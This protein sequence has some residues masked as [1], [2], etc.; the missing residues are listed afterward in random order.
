M[1]DDD[2]FEPRLGKMRAGGSKRGRKYLHQVLQAAGL[3]ASGRATGSRFH[4]SRIGRGAGVGR[5]LAAGDALGRF[6]H[7]RVIVKSRTVRLAGRGM[8]GAR[9][10]LRYLQRDGVTR[11]GEPGSLYGADRDVEDGK[12]FLERCAGDRHQFRFIVSAE[13]GA[14]YADLKPLT[15]RLMAQMEEDLGTRLDWVAVDHFNTGHPHTHILM[16]GRDDKGKDLILARAYLSTGMRERAAEIVSLD[17]GPRS[18]LEVQRRLAREIEQE[19]WTSLDRRLEAA[20]DAQGF[21]RLEGSTVLRAALTGRLAKLERMGLAEPDPEGRWHLAEDI[22][23]T[24][25]RMGERGDI[26]KTMHREMGRGGG[27]IGARDY[28]IFAPGDGEAKPLVGRV[29][30]RGLS[31]ELRDRHYLIVEATDGRTY[32][33]DIGS[34]DALESL[35]GGAV[36]RVEARPA[37]VRVIDRNVAEI[38]AA[39]HGRYSVDLHLRHD[40]SASQAFAETHVRRLEAM[41]RVTGAADREPDGSWRIAPDHLE[42]AAAFEQRQLRDRPVGIE[43]LSRL[44]LEQQLAYDGATWLDQQL[45]AAEPVPLRDAGFGAA[46]RDAQRLRQRWLIDE[47]L[48][49]EGSG[50]PVFRPDLVAVL[51]RRELRRVARQLSDE[52]GLRFAETQ[53]G[54]AVD[55]ILRRHVDLASGRFAVVEKSREFTLVPWRPVL[56]RQIG[57]RVGGIVRENGVSWS[58]GR[59]RGGPAIS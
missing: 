16:R 28:A 13:D 54:D 50:E 36:V 12:V 58:F 18:D 33:V 35:P 48:A 26:I 55:G 9:A 23:A 15:R 52:L 31:D 39:N 4:C 19:R 7:R 32:Y 47:G 53:P 27:G 37:Q 2:S 5:V 14:E 17:L 30:A 8:Q 10:H 6:R 25:R 49:G 20:I 38:A 34:G 40:P 42:R 41:R 57:K 44:P 59:E 24:L 22:E 43:I 1:K 45:V 56:E 29:A 51:R 11:D 21:V 3:A 46:A